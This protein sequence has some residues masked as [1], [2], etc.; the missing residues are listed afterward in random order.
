MEIGYDCG[1]PVREKRLTVRSGEQV[2]PF[3]MKVALDEPGR[4]I[5]PGNV[6]YLLGGQWLKR[7]ELPI[8]DRK[9]FSFYRL[10]IRVDDKTV[11]EE[12]ISFLRSYTNSPS[13]I[14]PWLSCPRVPGFVD[15]VVIAIM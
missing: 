1:R 4:D 14:H 15:F 6:D 9:R 12:Y 7:K 3:E 10:L 13:F 5:E 2:D 11:G 8:L